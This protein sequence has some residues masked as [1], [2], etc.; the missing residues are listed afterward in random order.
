M[1]FL[2]LLLLSF[3]SLMYG[4]HMSVSSSTSRHHHAA[5]EGEEL[6]PTRWARR[7]R[8][9]VVDELGRRLVLGCIVHG[10]GKTAC[11]RDLLQQSK[12]TGLRWHW[13]R[14]KEKIA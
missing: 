8:G 3:H 13:D 10:L 11:V 1:T 4:P 7:G 14:A 9:A 2:P 5:R 12:V 6:Q